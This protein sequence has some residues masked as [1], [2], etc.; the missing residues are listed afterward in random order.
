M[1]PST[2]YWF[3]S[4]KQMLNKN[5]YWNVT[6]K[7]FYIKRANENCHVGEL[8]KRQAAAGLGG[9]EVLGVNNGRHNG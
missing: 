1:P 3:E 9:E 7:P 2:G 6:T 4:R 5:N 8:M